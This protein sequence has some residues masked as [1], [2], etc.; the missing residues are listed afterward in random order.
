[1]HS[2]VAACALSTAAYQLTE[3]VR[4]K[5]R[6]QRQNLLRSVRSSVRSNG[7]ICFCRE[8]AYSANI[9]AVDVAH[10]NVRGDIVFVAAALS[11][12]FNSAKTLVNIVNLSPG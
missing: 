6:R 3:G 2:S 10:R 8:S 12:K 5:I 9:D 11:R 7:D 4:S 1:M